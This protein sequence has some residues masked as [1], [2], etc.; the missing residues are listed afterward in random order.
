MPS[1]PT[2]SSPLDSPVGSA[3]QKNPPAIVE[4]CKSLGATGLKVLYGYLVFSG[5]CLLVVVLLIVIH[6]PYQ[7]DELGSPRVRKDAGEFYTDIYSAGRAGTDAPAAKAG[8]EAVPV[9]VPAPVSVAVSDPSPA[10]ASDADS[11][12][13]KLAREAIEF[14]QIVPKITAFA[15]QYGL[16]DKRVLDVGA[17]TGYLQDV[18]RNYVGLDISPSARRYFHKPFVEASATDMPFHDNEFDA[19]WTVWVLEHVP[20]PEQALVEIRRVVKDGGLLYLKPAW[21]CT[22]WLAQGYQV[23]PYSDFDAMGK[24]RKASLIF[25]ASDNYRGA[26]LIPTRILRQTQVRWSGQPTRF[27]YKLLQ[28]NYE[29]Y[30]VPDSDAVN[31]LDYYEMLLWFTSRGDEC[32][33]CDSEPIWDAKELILR[34][35]KN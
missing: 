17:G 19:L 18:V 21:D 31:G 28:P 30:W 16:A 9:A 15:R 25:E 22:W 13:V 32:L 34:V 10:P 24:L 3:P 33:N 20:K 4:M 23:R 7:V 5:I 1:A 29:Q 27:H 35:H 2:R 26:S 14:Q 6:F 11:K 8:R 12:Y